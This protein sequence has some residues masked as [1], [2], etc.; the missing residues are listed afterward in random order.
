MTP[1]LIGLLGCI[2]LLVLL[3]CSMPVALSMG[4]VGIAGF[5]AVIKGKAALAVLSADLYDVF[6]NYNLTVIPLFVFMGQVAFHTG[7]S[8]RLFK[9]ANCWLSALRGGLAR[10]RRQRRP[11]PPWPFRR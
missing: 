6:S 2:A 9:A 5:A 3:A 8:S 4:V 11:W 7:I 1:S 10:D